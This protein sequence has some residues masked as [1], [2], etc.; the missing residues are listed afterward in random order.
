MVNEHCY[1]LIQDIL[2]EPIFA[3]AIHHNCLMK[4]FV[5]KRSRQMQKVASDWIAVLFE[6]KIS[7]IWKLI[8]KKFRW[9]PC[10]KLHASLTWLGILPNTFT[11]I[12][13]DSF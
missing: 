3:E 12:L 8:L 7:S 2:E 13:K 9:S 11:M 10:L 5:L 1:G 4:W 6:E